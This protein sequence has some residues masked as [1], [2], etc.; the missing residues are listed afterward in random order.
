[1]EKGK[2]TALATALALTMACGCALVEKPMT[3][4]MKT[5]AP[6]DRPY[7]IEPRTIMV[8]D[9][10]IKYMEAGEGPWVILIHGGVI[11]MNTMT[12]V[13][14]QFSTSAR[15]ILHSNAVAA[16]DSWNYNIA[17]L[18]ARNF[19]VVALDLPGFGGSD[20][21]D[22]EYRLEE[23][24]SYLDGFMSAKGIDRAMLVGH[25]LGGE[26]AMVYALTYPDKVDKLVLVDSFGGFGWKRPLFAHSPLNMRFIMKYWQKEKAAHI[27]V[28]HPRMRKMI[29]GWKKPAEAA[30]ADVL[31]QEVTG[32]HPK[33]II[34]SREDAG[35]QFIDSVT[36]FKLAYITTE[37][38]RKE[39]HALHRAL[40]ET[41]RKDLQKRMGEIK[42]PVLIIQGARDSV[43][44]VEQARFL[45]NRM[46][47]SQMMVYESSGHYPMVE[48]A[49]R[50]NQ[51]VG[52]F[53]SGSVTARNAP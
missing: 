1:M 25:G 7:S 39:A 48:E 13:Y 21:P 14:Y 35:G 10:T 2:I 36:E 26:I 27:N 46:P 40:M 45:E 4:R 15:D 28:C 11:P 3:G 43:V 37:E 20:K 6:V 5:T 52:F 41:K 16:A 32:G 17:E 18:A 47:A 31:S 33:N 42:A 9:L 49:E 24:A 30:I 51:D 29:R 53:L 22:I 44:P 34:V 8:D 12:S 19:H 23:F 38:S 50:F